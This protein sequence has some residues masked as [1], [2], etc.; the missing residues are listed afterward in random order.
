M[1]S[2]MRCILAVVLVTLFGRT[3]WADATLPTV[4]PGSQYEIMFVTSDGTTATSSNIADYNS[5]VTQEA[6]QSNVLKSLSATWTAV[7]STPTFSASSASLSN[8]IAIYDTSGNLL[9][10]TFPDIF[11]DFSFAGPIFDQDGGRALIP[12]VWTGTLFPIYYQGDNSLGSAD[13]VYGF[14]GLNYGD[15]LAGAYGP[16]MEDYALYGISSPITVPTP[17]PATLTLLGSAL[18]GFGVIYLRRR[19]AAKT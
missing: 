12:N 4:P 1:N 6:D 2:M 3:A 14:I 15:W 10:H 19:R 17:E 7:A 8:T 11:T 16:S 13:P 5:F 18:L 9:E